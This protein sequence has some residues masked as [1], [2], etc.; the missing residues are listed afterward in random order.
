MPNLTT[1]QPVPM[2]KRRQLILALAAAGALPSCVEMP[3]GSDAATTRIT[4]PPIPREFRAAW[5]AT[6][7]NIDWPSKKG[8]TAAE[9]QKE[10]VAILNRAASLNLN[11]LILQVRPCADAIYASTIEPWSEFLTG[12]QGKA[13][14]P[15]YDPLAL[16]IEEA[17]KRGI[18]LHAWFNPYRARHTMS[19]SP[20][21]RNHVAN[22]MPE[23]VKSYGGFLWMDPADERASRQT[24]EVIMDVVKRY[25]IDGVHID[26][27]FYP[28]PVRAPG[29]GADAPE[30]EFPD[31]P[32]WQAYQR[33]GGTLA[34]ADWRRSKV[35]D[36][37]EAIH[38]HIKRV[39]PWVS[40]GVSPFG[41][42]RPDR[43]PPGIAGFSQ[44]DK[45]YADVEHWLA[46]GWM[47]YLAPQ[48]YW[49]IEQKAQAYGVLLDYWLQQNVAGRHVWPGIYTSRI[50]ATEKSWQP[51]EIVNQIALTRQRASPGLPQS[52]RVQGHIHFS[53]VALTQNRRR[54]SDRLAPVYAH[55]AAT[56]VMPWVG[57]AA[58]PAPTVDV[59][60]RAEPA[61][62]V[63][64][65]IRAETTARARQHAVW[66]R[67]GTDWQLT[68]AGAPT[69]TVTIPSERAGA[70]ID[71][72]VISTLDVASLESPRVAIP[73]VR[74]GSV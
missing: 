38:T 67:Y 71:A 44:F 3:R 60:W 4:A 69:E 12:T 42:G 63:T 13:P 37:V 29:A 15:H 17:H 46:S 20:N 8:L 5:V 52:D 11:A 39:K 54:I 9:Q 27:Y 53:I 65:R 18:A 59:A 43:R 16:W 7:A 2:T 73:L 68:L 74:P 70:W 22:T 32:T 55:P 1:T 56:P 64:L 41:V 36:L 61:S 23:A 35:N 45:L 72:I 14:E 19:A 57:G 34:R 49:P 10:M 31:G 6:V 66:A 21:A 33:A 47:D 50:D 28:Y 40:F 30:I 25:D 51:E 48:L 26:D 58:P 24:L 62:G